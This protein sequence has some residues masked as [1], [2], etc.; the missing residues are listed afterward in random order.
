MVTGKIDEKPRLIR[1]EKVDR[2]LSDGS[3]NTSHDRTLH[4]LLS[5]KINIEEMVNL[6]N[7]KTY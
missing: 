1:S 5:G 6:I 2:R 7:S 3:M 4:H